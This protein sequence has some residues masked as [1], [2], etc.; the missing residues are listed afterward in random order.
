MIK[1]HFEMNS[2]VLAILL[3]IIVEDN[4]PVNVTTGDSH[5]DYDGSASV[6]VLFEYDYRDTDIVNEAL[7]RAINLTFD[8]VE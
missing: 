6:D 7:C 3:E 8:L 5:K 1:N 4:I 2:K